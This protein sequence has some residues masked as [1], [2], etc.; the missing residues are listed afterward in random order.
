MSKIKPWSKKE[1]QILIDKYSSHT[2][3]EIKN[4]FLVERS[5]QSIYSRANKI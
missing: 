5:I 4:L 1:D 2:A 3:K